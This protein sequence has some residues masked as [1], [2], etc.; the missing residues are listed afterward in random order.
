MEDAEAAQ[1]RCKW[2]AF[3][4]DQGS[5]RRDGESLKALCF[6][7]IPPSLRGHAWRVLLGNKMRINQE[8][9]EILKTQ[10]EET[11]FV[12]EYEDGDT[13]T[14]GSE[15]ET[16]DDLVVSAK[17]EEMNSKLNQGQNT[18]DDPASKNSCETENDHDYVVEKGDDLKDVVER[19]STS[20]DMQDRAPMRRKTSIVSQ[21]E[22]DLGRTFPTLAFFN[23]EGPYRESLRE[24]LECFALFRPGLGYVQGM[25]HVAAFLLLNMEKQH[26][27]AC[28]CNIL[29]DHKM[30]QMLR[31]NDP[32][33]LQRQIEM[34]DALIRDFVPKLHE[35]FEKLGLRPD[36]FMVNWL[37]TLFTNL[38]LDVSARIWDCYLFY[39]T[40]DEKD[41]FLART[42]IALLRL[43]DVQ[44]RLLDIN[45]GLSVL[46]SPRQTL[47]N[48]EKLITEVKKVGLTQWKWSGYL[49]RANLSSLHL[50]SSFLS[51][52]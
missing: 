17:G 30:Y 7:G 48:A 29:E 34:Y 13:I 37:L 16:D 21:I 9:F 41:R 32:S 49:K 4:V 12:T 45:Q 28:Y 42:T 24:I 46:R 43:L 23:D 38:P 11:R 31:S 44:L 20:A 1:Q 10:A 52:Q 39:G 33:I 25:S 26:A 15:T 40:K 14:E 8:L 51:I 47:V 5:L 2:K 18:E 3:L 19:D 27:F 35:H 6:G 36:M 22:Q 50:S